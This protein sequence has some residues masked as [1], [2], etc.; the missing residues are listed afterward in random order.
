MRIHWKEA[1]PGYERYSLLVIPRLSLI[2]GLVVK[3]EFEN[4]NNRAKLIKQELIEG[5]DRAEE[6]WSLI[7]VS[8]FKIMR[9]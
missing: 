9:K 6:E 4:P 1:N 3:E 5:A 7:N 2:D 8:L